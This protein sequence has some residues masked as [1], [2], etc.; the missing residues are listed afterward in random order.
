MLDSRQDAPSPEAETV[1]ELD[2]SVQRSGSLI[3]LEIKRISLWL[4]KEIHGRRLLLL[5]AGTSNVSLSVI[6]SHSLCFM[7]RGC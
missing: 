2:R 4:N 1:A 7:F 6:V 3:V 5:Q